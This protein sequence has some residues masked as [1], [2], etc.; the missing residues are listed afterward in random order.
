MI[1]KDIL[2]LIDLSINVRTGTSKL[3]NKSELERLTISSPVDL[4]LLFLP[5]FCMRTPLQSLLTDN[6]FDVFNNLYPGIVTFFRDFITNQ[7]YIDKIVD[8]FTFILKYKVKYPKAA[9]EKYYSSLRYDSNYL[10][11]EESETLDKIEG[12]Q[13]YLKLIVEEVWKK[14]EF[15]SLEFLDT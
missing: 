3:F 13:E 8:M 7:Q 6:D 12:V 1:Q 4:L 11:D 15:S 14:K 5:D 9:I 10:S 2:D